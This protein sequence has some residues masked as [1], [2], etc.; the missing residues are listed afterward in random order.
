MS[1][2]SQVTCGAEWGCV[3]EWGTV[4]KAVTKKS[5]AHTSETMRCLENSKEGWGWERLAWQEMRGRQG[6]LHVY[7]FILCRVSNAGPLRIFQESN[8]VKGARLEEDTPGRML[9]QCSR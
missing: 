3:L 6:L 4:G 1:R 2:V 8:A 7:R 5:K 9:W